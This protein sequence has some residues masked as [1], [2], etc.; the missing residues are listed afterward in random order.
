MFEEGAEAG[1]G[2]VDGGGPGEPVDHLALAFG[3]GRIGVAA[4]D[5]VT[6]VEVRVAPPTRVHVDMDQLGD[7]T[8]IDRTGEADLEAGL[9]PT[10]AQ[11]CIPGGLTDVD[12]A[13]GLQPDAEPL[14]FQQDHTARSNHDARPRHVD[15]I[16]LEVERGLQPIERLQERRD[17][18]DLALVNR[19]P[20]DDIGPNALVEVVAGMRHRTGVPDLSA[21]DTRVILWHFFLSSSVSCRY[22]QQ[23]RERHQADR[24]GGDPHMDHDTNIAHRILIA[25]DDP[26]L[27]RTSVAGLRAAGFSVSAPT[28]GDA[29]IMLAESFSPDVLI[30]CSHLRAPDGRP[31][32]ERLRDSSE[33]YLLCITDEGAHR[34]RAAVLHSGADDA[35]SMPVLPEE[36][37][38]RCHA[39]LRRP[40]QM[41]NRVDSPL[42][43]VLNLGPL[44][45]DLGRREV[46]IDDEE[47]ATTRIEFS[48]LEQLCR[49]P[50]EVCTR[51]DLLDAVW[52]P[53]WVGDNHVVDVHLSNLRRKLD[54]AGPDYKV[55]HTVRGVGFRLANDVTDQLE[56]SHAFGLAAVG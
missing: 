53:T 54:K 13:A 30:V 23:N 5:Q 31:L 14:V 11:R 17:R 56:I 42:T 37:S 27:R 8:I 52:G 34:A 38:A 19:H 15:R 16:A 22:D 45:I 44:T 1:V 10:L 25:V 43:S 35:V 21:N 18:V 33:Q 24:T 49:R 39:L 20:R 48:L 40:R 55:I 50:T 9:L 12:V 7:T 46:R 32:Y 51:E 2:A 3:W 36:L 41:H 47:V 26:D 28:D 4:V 6:Q 29:A